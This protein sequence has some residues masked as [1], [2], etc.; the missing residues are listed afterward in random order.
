MKSNRACAN[1]GSSGHSAN[2]GGC[3]VY[4]KAKESL[5][6]RNKQKEE[7]HTKKIQN[8]PTI[9]I[10]NRHADDFPVLS[11]RPNNQSNNQTDI[12]DINNLPQP[13]ISVTPATSNPPESAP[14]ENAF[15][16]SFAEII[17]DSN[18]N[19]GVEPNF[20][21]FKLKRTCIRGSLRKSRLAGLL[22]PE[23][24]GLSLLNLL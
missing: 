3:P 16:K 2:Y 14:S 10:N 24:F 7:A 21:T 23:V 15:Q 8:T 22:P 12:N 6:N 19:S 5:I 13:S 11:T 9:E 17:T 4:K 1:C 18:T 20:E